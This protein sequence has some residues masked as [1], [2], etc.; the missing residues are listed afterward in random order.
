MRSCNKAT[1]TVERSSDG[2]NMLGLTLQGLTLQGLTSACAATRLRRVGRPH[3]S[4]ENAM[5]EKDAKVYIAGHAG[6]VGSAVWRRLE[7]YGCTNLVGRRS[8]QLDLTRQDQT[9]AFMAQE[10]PE[11]VVLAAAKVGGIHANNIYP[12]DFIYLNSAIQTNLIHACSLTGVKRLLF[13]GSSCIYPKHA[14]QPI[15]EEHLLTGPLEPTNEAYAVAKIAG[16][17]MCEYYNKQY[18]T[19]YWQLMPSNLYGPNDNFD[20]ETSHVVP[21]LLRKFHE[22]R[23]SGTGPVTVWGTGSPRREFV[24]VDDM[25]DACLFA[26]SHPGVDYPD[27]LFNVGWGND[28]TIREL[29]ETVQR[30]VGYKGDVVWDTSKPDGTPRKLLDNSKLAGLGWTPSIELEDGLRQTYQWY[31][32]AL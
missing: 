26:L 11:Y 25:A 15:K 24:H 16:L 12:A 4:H 23:Q 22:A 9:E 13:L 30:V 19:D 21:A 7:A 10:K 31:C 18:G 29:V 32:R 6:L 20:L 8:A 28:V 3:F 17:K 14:P 5:I 1:A 2:V 27:K